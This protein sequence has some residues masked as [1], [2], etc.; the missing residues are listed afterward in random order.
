MRETLTFPIYRNYF[1]QQSGHIA[2]WPV[3]EE[4]MV[5]LAS[6]MCLHGVALCVGRTDQAVFASIGR[7]GTHCAITAKG[8]GVLGYLTDMKG[9][10][11]CRETLATVMLGV[12]PAGGLLHIHGNHIGDD[13]GAVETR[14]SI[15]REEDTVHVVRKQVVRPPEPVPYHRRVGM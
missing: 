10:E 5:S 8:A 13:D 6:M 14:Y 9:V 12:I 15:S 1:R 7:S 3:A 2:L 11:V 4:D